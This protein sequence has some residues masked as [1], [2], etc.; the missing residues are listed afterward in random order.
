MRALCSAVDPDTALE[1]RRIVRS[2]SRY[3]GGGASAVSNSEP[4]V[5]STA[6]G[7]S[8]SSGAGSYAFSSDEMMSG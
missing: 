1:R 4:C 7:G 3:S 5:S 2:G 6:S 8:T